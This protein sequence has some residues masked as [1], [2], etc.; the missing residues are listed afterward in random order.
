MIV[1]YLGL[2]CA[3]SFCLLASADEMNIDMCAARKSTLFSR[4]NR[5]LKALGAP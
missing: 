1:F 5:L 4:A 3:G 2:L